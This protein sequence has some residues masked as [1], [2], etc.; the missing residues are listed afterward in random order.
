MS[1]TITTP[2]V[3]PTIRERVEA[4]AAWLDST[5]PAWR[6]TINTRILDMGNSSSCVIGQALHAE[7]ALAGAFSPY[8]H[9]FAT[10]F[11][12]DESEMVRHGFEVDA[13]T[14]DVLGAA[15][16]RYLND[17]DASRIALHRYL[18]GER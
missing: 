4:G 18:T 16:K 6:D 7:A 9:V 8:F 13:E 12:G 14:Y 5:A 2:A 11:E 15:W 10:Y 3:T 1:E 17:S